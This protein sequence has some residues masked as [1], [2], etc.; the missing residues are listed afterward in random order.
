MVNSVFNS[1]QNITKTGTLPAGSVVLQYVNDLKLCSLM[2]DACETDAKALLKYIDKGIKAH[3]SKLQFAQTSVPYLG[4]VIT[5]EG[6][7]LS[8]KCVEAS[9][10]SPNL[11]PRNR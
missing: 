8:P 10:Q 7:S 9:K 2:N 5:A 3:L 4:H 11:K 6:K 1:A